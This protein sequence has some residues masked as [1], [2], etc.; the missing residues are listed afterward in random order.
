MR[1]TILTTILA[2]FLFSPTAFGS[3]AGETIKKEG[4]DIATATTNAPSEVESS[5][6]KEVKAAKKGA[7]KL[8]PFK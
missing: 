3:G 4:E 1:Y 8:N 2:A 6:E 5:T 7:D